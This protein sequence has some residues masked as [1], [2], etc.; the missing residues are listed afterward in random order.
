MRHFFTS[1]VTVLFFL[2][3]ML[4]YA[5]QTTTVRGKVLDAGSRPVEGASVQLAGTARGTSTS[6]SGQYR[7]TGVRQG[8]YTLRI[9]AVGF[10]PTEKRIVVKGE[11]LVVPD[12]ELVEKAEELIGVTVSSFRA[13]KFAEKQSQT[14]AKMPLKDLENPQVYSSIPNELLTEQITTDFGNV[15][16]N[17]PGVYKVQGNRNINTDGGSFYTIR[18]FRTGLG[19][20]DGVL[21]ETNAEY[22]PANVEKVEVLKGPSGTLY[23]GQ[24][25]SF[26]GLVNIITK[27]PLDTFGGEVTYTGGS[28]DLNRV[29][30]DIYG[31]VNKRGN[32][33]FRVNTAYQYQ[34]S[35][36][37]AGFKRT[38]FVAPVV[39]YRANERLNI[40][41]N[42]SFY[43]G[44][45]TSPSVLFLS[46]T[47]PFI[48][49]RPE[50]LHFDWE[51]SYTSNDITMENPTTN[52]K[53]EV[54]YKI[55]DTWNSQTIVAYNDRRSKGFY[56][57][58]FIRKATD[59]TLERNIVKMNTIN[60]S[61][62]I[63]QNFTGDFRIAGLR[64]RL[65]VGFDYLDQTVKND[66]SPYIVFDYVN[67]VMPG[68]N[69]NDLTRAA[70]EARL[71]ESEG[72]R[73]ENRSSNGM[74]GIYA[75]NMLNMTDDLMAMFSLR[76]D[77]FWNDTYNQTALSPKFGLVYQVVKDKVSLFGNYMN[78]FL[79]VSP[80]SQPLP[81]ISGIFE[82]Q[83]AN[84][85]EGGVKMNLFNNKLALTASYY[86]IK[87]EN[88]TYRDGLVR[89][90]QEYSVTVQDGTQHSKGVELEVIA[91]PV[92]GLNIIAG[93]S[94]ND[95]ELTKGVPAL[96][97][98]RPA[99]A[100]PANLVNAWVSYVL[101]KGKLK[102]LGV[103]A[104]GNYVGK[105]L[106][107]NSAVTGVFTLPAYTLV[108]ATAFYDTS[109]Y[110]LGIKVDNL[111][112]ERYFVGQGVIAPQMRRNFAANLVIKF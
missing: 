61:T 52:L 25:T 75:S 33:L 34:N 83:H 109:H 67:G 3:G 28:N 36:Q 81:D 51:R 2:C 46:R 76:V 68:D 96:V 12:L 47:R 110:R 11:T 4:S 77:R 62:N 39:E 23:G 7:I 65:V 26:G 88:M 21:G 41:L 9:T 85:A 19:L 24:V 100:G 63:Q 43:H 86:Y 5:Q 59:D 6:A 60:T 57:Y 15:L 30:A 102:G 111:A 29:A 87:V 80:V 82:P 13:N 49:T 8:E 98:R 103:G 73:T 106:T 38:F 74:A 97:N 31:P 107:S 20:V 10:A 69:Y 79:N 16:K 53:G 32:L 66:N 55:S 94:Y 95:S 108:N 71:A 35:F 40:K 50:E 84:Q 93:Y 90:G 58:Q 112:N 78:G 72:P 37:D 44:E 45:S 56:Q 18:G 99:S 54:N 89:D 17:S 1:Y 101:P 92:E 70:V 14:V 104:G 22:D 42:T 91:N 27:K 48:A 64:N 105:H